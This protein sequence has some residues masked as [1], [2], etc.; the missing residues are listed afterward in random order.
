MMQADQGHVSMI[1]D[2]ADSVGSTWEHEA[3]PNVQQ[4]ALN[5][6]LRN[7]SACTRAELFCQICQS[8]D[9]A[10][11]SNNFSSNRGFNVLRP[12]LIGVE[13]SSTWTADQILRFPDAR[14]QALR[15]SL[16]HSQVTYGCEISY[17]GDVSLLEWFLIRLYSAYTR[18]LCYR[19]AYPQRQQPTTVDTGHNVLAV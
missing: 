15:I 10:W 9:E 17:F 12:F 16:S 11:T 3:A 14:T 18:I 7:T 6:L 8:F 4:C 19:D 1:I 2:D 13:D 5:G